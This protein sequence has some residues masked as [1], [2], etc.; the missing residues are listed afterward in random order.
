ME[1]ASNLSDQKLSFC[2]ATYNR[3]RFLNDTLRSLIAQATEECEIVVSD[4][5]STDETEQVVSYYQSHFRRLRYFK[6]NINVG[7]DQNF[8]NAVALARGEFCW[9]M[10]DDDTLK[11]GSVS[12]ILGALRPE[13]SLILVNMEVRDISMSS[14]QIRRWLNINSDRMYAPGET[15]RLFTD[16]NGRVGSVSNIIIRRSIWINRERERYYGSMFI[17]TGVL[18]QEPL[19]GRT[20]VVAAPLINYRS[21]NVGRW[22]CDAPEIFL[23]KWPDVISSLAISDSA[24]RKVKVTKPWSHFY[25]LLILRSAGYSLVEYRRWVRPRLISGYEA[26]LPISIALVPRMLIKALVVLSGYIDNNVERLLYLHE[27]RHL[28]RRRSV[29]RN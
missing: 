23:G 21:G 28:N 3:A 25:S 27:Q 15:D 10:G 20:L 12:T 19:P 18:F 8:D 1:P 9:L 29:R 16:L 4:N 17:H 13:L 24:K 14:V 11:P 22:F 26:I 7:P 5:A 2:I 6:Q